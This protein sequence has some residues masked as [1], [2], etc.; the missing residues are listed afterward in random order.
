[1]TTHTRAFFTKE[2]CDRSSYME[3]VRRQKRC[4][5]LSSNQG[6]IA[7]YYTF[8]KVEGEIGHFLSVSHMHDCSWCVSVQQQSS[9]IDFQE[10]IAS[11]EG[12]GT[13]V[14]SDG[15]RKEAEE[16]LYTQV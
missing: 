13:D 2:L 14:K 6:E 9:V 7:F 3:S 8:K 12:Q 11:G 4:F 15:V 1:M 10:V 5:F 16:L